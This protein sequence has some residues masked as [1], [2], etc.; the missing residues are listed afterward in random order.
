VIDIDIS[1][2][3]QDTDHGGRRNPS[4]GKSRVAAY[5]EAAS[6]ADGDSAPMDVDVDDEDEKNPASSSETDES[7][8]VDEDEDEPRRSRRS[9]NAPTKKGK[10]AVK[11]VTGRGRARAESVPTR[12]SSRS[13]KFASSLAEPSGESIRDLLD[14]D[15]EYVKTGKS[16][17]ASGGNR[18][19]RDSTDTA[20]LSDVDEETTGETS[21]SRRK[22][23][24]KKGGVR[25]SLGAIGPTSPSKSPAR[26]HSMNRHSLRQDEE[27]SGD[28]EESSEEESEG[29][30]EGEAIR[31]Q[32]VLACRTEKLTKWREICQGINTSEI[33]TGSRW[34][35]S[36]DENDDKKD[37]SSEDDT[38]EERFLVKWSDLSYLHCSWE[39]RYDIIE[40]VEGA[41][42]YLSTFFRKSES[43]V[44]FSADERCDGDYFDPAFTQIDRILEIQFSTDEDHPTLTA[45]DEDRYTASDFGIV[46]DKSAEE[47]EEGTGRQFLIKWSHTPYSECTF[48]FERDLI[49]NET[50]YKDDVKGFLR[51]NKKP[52]KSDLRTRIRKGEEELRRSYKF[53]GDRSTIS[54]EKRDECVQKYQQELQERVFPNGGQLRDYQA[55]G[56]SWMMSNFVNQRSSILADEMGLGKFIW[57][58]VCVVVGNSPAPGGWIETQHRSNCKQHYAPRSSLLVPHLDRQDL[59]NMR[60]CQPHRQQIES[61]RARFNRRSTINTCALA[62]R[63]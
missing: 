41:K 63:V 42:T 9:A 11:A 59:A 17:K 54:D 20:E 24:S 55:E 15:S 19:N 30:D 28:S 61:R 60:N 10:A 29:E 51:R 35:Q 47:Y 8:N 45:E 25:D 31:I 4:R 33:D 53:F 40:Q 3:L 34:F 13:T 62:A 27:A 21:T 16:R 37:D 18:T 12:T 57:F 2:F 22:V 49:L 58:R 32:R 56:V 44:L 36:S 46:M 43:G 6:E 1:Y 26:R 23:L 14:G 5:N 7:L 50:D 48:E 39:T 38:F 52:T